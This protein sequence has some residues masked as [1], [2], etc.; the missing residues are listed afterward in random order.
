MLQTDKYRT[1]K[2]KLS[3]LKGLLEGRNT[4][5]EVM[6]RRFFM[7]METKEEAGIYYLAENERL[8]P[9]EGDTRRYTVKEIE[10]IRRMP[11]T[12]VTKGKFV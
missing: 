5:Y 4:I 3:Y 9:K 2:Q 6:K 12:L 1:R 8:K 10:R 11:N 7:F